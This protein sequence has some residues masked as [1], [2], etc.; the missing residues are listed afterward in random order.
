M[1]GPEQVVQSRDVPPAGH[2]GPITVRVIVEELHAFHL[3]DV[4]PLREHRHAEAFALHVVFQLCDFGGGI[5]L[6]VVV[7]CRRTG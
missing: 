7:G 6:R 1:K 2:R 5:F 4:V 3:L